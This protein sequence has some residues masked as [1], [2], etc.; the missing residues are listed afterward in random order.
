MFMNIP[1]KAI[2]ININWSL[3]KQQKKRGKAI[4]DYGRNVYNKIMDLTKKHCIPCEGGTPPLLNEKED[5]LIG[6]ISDWMLVRDGM[7]KITRQFK[8]KDFKKAMARM[9]LDKGFFNLLERIA[10]QEREFK[11]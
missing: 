8:F 5:E 10:K 1:T 2:H 6:Q 3:F 7:H 9:I 4:A 11:E